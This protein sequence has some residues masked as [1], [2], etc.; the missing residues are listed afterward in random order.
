MSK[1]TITV[2]SLQECNRP[3]GPHGARG[4]CPTHY[5]RWRATGDPRI[6]RFVTRG[7]SD[8]E[9]LLHYLDISDPSACWEWQGVRDKDGYGHVSG[10]ASPRISSRV[11]YETWVGPIP[12]RHLICHT[13]DNPPCC[14][15]AHLFS[16]TSKRNTQDMLAKWRGSHG[17]HH[18]WHRLTDEQ[19]HVIRYLSEQGIQQ[20]PIAKLIGCSQSQ[21]S[22]IVRR[23]QRRHDTNWTPKP[24]LIEWVAK[25]SRTHRLAV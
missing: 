1:S 6:T 7:A 4:W 10:A 2:C 8:E 13:C 17:E 3:I 23:S 25:N 21:V 14:N 16:G 15:P 19:V 12:A 9:R 11:A 22:N 18:H 24:A 20:R 5:K